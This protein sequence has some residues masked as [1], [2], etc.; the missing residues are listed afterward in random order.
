M[1]NRQFKTSV[2][3]LSFIRYHH[4]DDNNIII[5]QNIRMEYIDSENVNYSRSEH[6]YISLN[7]VLYLNNYKYAYDYI[8]DGQQFVCYKKK[9]MSNML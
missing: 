6:G 1:A 7:D 9:Y 3:V 5:P 8:D 4:N 2:D